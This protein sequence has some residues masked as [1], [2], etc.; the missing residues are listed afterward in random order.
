MV[1]A[2]QIE[3]FWEAWSQCPLDALNP[4][5]MGIVPDNPIID[6]SSGRQPVGAGMYILIG[7]GANVHAEPNE[8][9]NKIPP[10]VIWKC[11]EPDL[12]VVT[13]T[14]I[15]NGYGHRLEGGWVSMDLFKLKEE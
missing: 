11:P 2:V 14:T 9:S 13:I 4:A 1:T 6:L 15:K 10:F 7:N 3:V 8:N 12:T 5:F